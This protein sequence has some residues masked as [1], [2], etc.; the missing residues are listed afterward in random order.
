MPDLIAR[1]FDAP[2]E[3]VEMDHMRSERVTVAGR[4][5]SRDSQAP[6]FRWSTHLKPTVGTEWCEV[7][8]VGVVLSGRLEG[9]HQNGETFA[10]GPMDVLDIPPGHDGW[11]SGDEP[12]VTIQWS[13]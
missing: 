8:H 7:H 4:V 13:T 3:V 12:F 6:G 9:V 5:I 1:N 11:V 2:D 10:F